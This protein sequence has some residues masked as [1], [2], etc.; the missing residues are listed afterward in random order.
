MVIKNRSLSTSR[1][2]G[3]DAGGNYACRPHFGR[4]LQP[5]PTSRDLTNSLTSRQDGLQVKLLTA[6][7]CEG[8]TRNVAQVSLD[9]GHWEGHLQLT[10]TIGHRIIMLHHRP[11][12]AA[13]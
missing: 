7:Y 1:N 5:Q 13:S 2:L 6:G 4:K 10:G 8:T 9:G 3:Q 12:V 11:T